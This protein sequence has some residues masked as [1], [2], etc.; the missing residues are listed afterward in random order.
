[1]SNELLIYLNILLKCQSSYHGYGHLTALLHANALFDS[2]NNNGC[3]LMSKVHEQS[4]VFMPVLGCEAH[5]PVSRLQ[6]SQ[7]LASGLSRFGIT[8]LS[9]SWPFI[10]PCCQT[11]L[12]LLAKRSPVPKV[13]SLS[14]KCTVTD[15][16]KAAISP[17]S[18]VPNVHK[19]SAQIT[20]LCQVSRQAAGTCGRR[21][22]LPRSYYCQ[23]VVWGWGG[24]VSL[25]VLQCASV[26][27]AHAV[28]EHL[29][30][31]VQLGVR[32]RHC[33]K[34]RSSRIKTVP[35][36]VHLFDETWND[37]VEAQTRLVQHRH[38]V[39]DTVRGL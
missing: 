3:K 2:T 19:T 18:A 14:L 26:H 25:R 10:L 4:S 35:G 22:S 29:N 5:Q 15:L 1:M 21:T 32:E 6:N 34:P 11:L 9:W 20:R 17:N 33:V 16:Q 12:P 28:D 8:E 39:H 23:R 27:D 37:L 24:P 31:L 13:L 36:C 7:V 38:K 30:I